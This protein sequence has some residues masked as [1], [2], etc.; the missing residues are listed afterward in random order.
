MQNRLSKLYKIILPLF[1]FTLCTVSLSAQNAQNQVVIPKQIFVGDSAELKITFSS[2]VDFFANIHTDNRNTKRQQNR[3]G[4][5]AIELT[6]QNFT[7]KIDGAEYTIK[8]IT[9]EKSA[10]NRQDTGQ[11]SYVFSII[12]TPWKTGEIKIPP[13][14]LGEAFG[15]ENDFL[16][17][18]STI[19]IDSILKQ[20]NI[21]PNFAPSKGPVLIPGTTYKIYFQIILIIVLLVAFI[22]VLI[23]WHD[24]NLFF[25]NVKLKLLYRRNK[26]STVKVLNKLCESKNTDREIAD[27]IQIVMRNYLQVR[28]DYPFTKS[29]TNE[30]MKGFDEIYCGLLD[31]AKADAVEDLTGIF[32]RTDFVRYGKDGQFE[33]GEKNRMICELL[34]IIETL[35][36]TKEQ[37]DDTDSKHIT[38]ARKSSMTNSVTPTDIVTEEALTNDD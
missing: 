32:I 26:K 13:Y 6:A 35:E 9:L 34:K 27:I 5:D 7:R 2:P 28:F 21:N 11:Q 30:L 22:R 24:V 33:S 8:K 37:N 19:E 23:K 4:T 29:A 15:F 1:V 36:N 25:K 17:T 12:F 10:A 38:T 18:P 20:K 31:D 16:I 14:N 3:N